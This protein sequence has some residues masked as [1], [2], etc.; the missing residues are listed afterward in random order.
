MI[1]VK[2]IILS[3]SF[4]FFANGLTLVLCGQLPKMWVCNKYFV[5]LQALSTLAILFAMFGIV[6]SDDAK[7][8]LEKHPVKYELIRTPVYR[9]IDSL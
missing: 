8:E 9:Q 2:L 4:L 6:I 3:L 1:V 5:L 7:N